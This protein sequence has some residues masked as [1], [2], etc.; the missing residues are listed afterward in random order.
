MKV[1]FVVSDIIED[2]FNLKIRSWLEE[3]GL[4][5]I[6]LNKLPHYLVDSDLEGEAFVAIN[7]HS[8]N[9]HPKR[10]CVHPAGNWNELWPHPAFDHL[11]GEKRKISMSSGNLLKSTYDSLVRNNHLEDFK[12]DVE[13]THHGPNVSR[14]LLFLEIG[15]TEKQWENDE[16]I[17]VIK[18]VILDLASKKHG[19]VRRSAIVLG[20][21][22]YMSNIKFLFKKGILVSHMCPSSMIHSLDLEILQEAIKN[23]YEN[24]FFVVDLPHVGQHQNK[25]I[26]YLESLEV[27]YHYLHDLLVS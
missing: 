11:G 4:P 1:T 9:D 21:D 3:K 23:N 27:E 2:N 14:P 5:F 10:F 16:A 24:T 19:E 20:G 7:V 15:S 13:C 12:V 22:H 6:R 17:E 25:I 8:L 26:E 18:K